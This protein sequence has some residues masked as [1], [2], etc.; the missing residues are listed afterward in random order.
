[1]VGFGE[2]EGEVAEVFRDLFAAGCR[3]LTVGQYLP[4]SRGHLPLT[5]YVSP[6]RFD[7]LAGAARAIGFDRVLSGPLVRSSYYQSKI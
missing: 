7:L 2:T 5:E 1:M 3:S 4:P 6:E